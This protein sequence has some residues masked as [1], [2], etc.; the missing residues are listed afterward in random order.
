GAVFTT[1]PPLAGTTKPFVFTSCPPVSAAILTAR[2]NGRPM[3][4]TEAPLKMRG[5][6]PRSSCRSTDRAGV[7]ASV[8]RRKLRL[9]GQGRSGLGCRGAH[10]AH[11]ARD[12]H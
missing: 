9:Q 5:I 8:F 1:D 10:E 3:Q 4:L 11:R 2:Q 6:G 7:V 12:D